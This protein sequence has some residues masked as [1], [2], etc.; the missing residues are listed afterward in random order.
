MVLDI[1]WWHPKMALHAMADTRCLHHRLIRLK[2]E[3][4][5]L[6]A[7]FTRHQTPQQAR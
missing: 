1:A 3:D 7:A 5:T 6:H 2:E 4:A